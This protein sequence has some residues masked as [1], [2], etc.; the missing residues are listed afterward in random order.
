MQETQVQSL[1]WED[2]LEKGSATHSSILA[3]R[4]PWTEEAGRLQPAGSQRVGHDWAWAHKLGLEML[5]HSL[6]SNRR[7]FFSLYTWRCKAGHI[8]IRA[9]GERES[10]QRGQA[11]EAVLRGALFQNCKQESKEGRGKGW[12]TPHLHVSSLLPCWPLFATD[13]TQLEEDGKGVLVIQSVVVSSQEKKHQRMQIRES[14]R[15]G[16]KNWQSHS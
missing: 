9:Y 13:W 3:W 15:A 6:C 11:I 2:A 7:N 8:V 12:P 5:V 14:R 1:C 16:E 4:I 10:C